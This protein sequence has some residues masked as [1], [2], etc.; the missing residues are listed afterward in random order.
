MRWEVL[1]HM[2]RAVPEDRQVALRTPMF[3]RRYLKMRG[4]TASAPLT[5]EEAYK[6]TYKARICGHNDCFVSSA[7]DVGTYNGPA[8][9]EFWQEDT[10]YT[11]MGGETCEKCPQSNGQHA[12]TEMELYHWSY[13]NRDYRESVTS[14]WRQ[15]GTMDEMMRRLGYRLVLE[16]AILTPSP[17]AGQKFEAYFKLHNRGFAAP[18]NKRG[19]ELILV[20]ANDPTK[21]YVYP[22]TVDPRFWL[23]EQE[24][25][26]T[27][28]C[29]LDNDMQGE[30]K[31]YL[32][33]P[34]G[35]ASLCDDPHYSI[36]LANENVW[37]E[38]TGYNYLTTITVE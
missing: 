10:K 14:M 5:A 23:P 33:L 20:K 25:T 15:D 7:S 37:E 11:F 17:K 21:K 9:R 18:M 6:N 29:T 30:Y 13:L 27:L 12:I 36:R 24:H 19:L 35:C 38:K 2:L 1:E 4:D 8:D 22:Q 3:K 28:S 34:D 31:L 16:K 32:N 26:F